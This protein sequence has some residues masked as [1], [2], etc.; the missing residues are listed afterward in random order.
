MRPP[1]I[2]PVARQTEKQVKKKDKGCPW[3][4]IYS[5]GIN[6]REIGFLVN[7]LV[8]GLGIDWEPCS[9]FCFR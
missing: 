7:G 1:D 5:C 3:R 4:I 6:C 2:C 8:A 9:Y